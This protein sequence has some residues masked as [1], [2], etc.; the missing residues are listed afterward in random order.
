MNVLGPERFSNKIVDCQAYS[1][2]CNGIDFETKLPDLIVIPHSV[3]DVIQVV[4]LANEYSVPIVPRGNGT[5][6]LGCNVA[7]RGG[8]MMDMSLMNKIIAIDR[9]NMVGVVEAGCVANDFFNRLDQQGLMYPIRPWFNP[10]MQMGAWVACNGN[11][12]FASSYGTVGETVVGLEVVLPSGEL[13]RLGS[14]ANDKGFGPFVRYPGGP[15]LIGLFTGSIGTLGVITKVAVRLLDKPRHVIYHSF[16]W[17]REEIDGVSKAAHAFLRSRNICNFSL[18]NYWSLLQSIHLGVVTLPKEIYFVANI[19]GFAN[20]ESEL[21]AKE[22]EIGDIGSAYAHDLGKDN[23]RGTHGPPHYVINVGSYKLRRSIPKRTTSGMAW[24][25]FYFYGPT[26]KFPEWWRF[27]E[28]KVSEHRFSDEKR[29][30]HL[31]A[32]AV[33]PQALAPFPAF[34]YRPDD[35][36]EV[37]RMKKAFNDIFVGLLKIGCTPYS[38]GAFI[39]VDQQRETLGSSYSLYQIVKCA[40]DPKGIFNPG[41]I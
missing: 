15:D 20:T 5:A 33:P 3:E 37:Q 24:C 35:Q 6:I 1:F 21:K 14:W 40:L 27:F 19:M 22:E 23:A 7:Q 28:E 34:A 41:Q 36:E 8:I 25:Q 4:R 39:P 12:D 11:G 31:F 30:P 10:Q 16:G 26:L 9:E 32:W 38:L 17:P 29:G 18:H 2:V 13:V